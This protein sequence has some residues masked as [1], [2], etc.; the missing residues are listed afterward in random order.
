MP[1]EV[2]GF[3][4][5]LSSG[6]SVD[7]GKSDIGWWWLAQIWWVEWEPPRIWPAVCL[8]SMSNLLHKFTK[9]SFLVWVKKVNSVFSAKFDSF[10]PVPWLLA[11]IRLELL[12]FGRKHTMNLQHKHLHPPPKFYTVCKGSA[13]TQSNVGF[14]KSV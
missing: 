5:C 1:I 14:F 12:H 8:N 13:Q 9:F 4:Y 11:K 3:C 6:K 10:S 7:T 2:R